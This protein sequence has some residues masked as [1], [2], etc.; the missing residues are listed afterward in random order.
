MLL[1]SVDFL[2]YYSFVCILITFIFILR[3]GNLLF[4]RCMRK[5]SLS[6]T[7]YYLSSIYNHWPHTSLFF[8]SAI[9]DLGIHTVLRVFRTKITYHSLFCDNH[10]C[11]FNWSLLRFQ[12][13]KKHSAQ[14]FKKINLCIVA[15]YSLY[16]IPPNAPSKETFNPLLLF[17]LSKMHQVFFKC[18]SLTS[19]W[20]QT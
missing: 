1:C 13:C 19:L 5:K 12:E 14:F 15:A 2:N 4:A 11:F 6:F 18:A 16:S 3:L 8:E 7:L 10:I 20:C 17:S 9:K